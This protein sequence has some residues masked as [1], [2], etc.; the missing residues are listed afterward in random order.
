MF[1][2]NKLLY[3]RTEAHHR[4]HIYF[5]AHVAHKIIGAG[6]VNWLHAPAVQS[7]AMRMS[8]A[9]AYAGAHWPKVRN[10]WRLKDTNVY[11]PSSAGDYPNLLANP[12]EITEASSITGRKGVVYFGPFANATGHVTLWNGATCHFGDGDAYWDTPTKYFWE[13]SL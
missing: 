5:R 9:L 11:F 2:V 7:C 8:I 10:S 4:D 6:D 13:M 3:A 12:E 1:Q